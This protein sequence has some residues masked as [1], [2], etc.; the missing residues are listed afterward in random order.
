MARS[1]SLRVQ[2]RVFTAVAKAL[3]D[4]RRD[5]SPGHADSRL[6]SPVRIFVEGFGFRVSQSGSQPGL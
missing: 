1:A 5:A 2:C 6:A 3:V 4:L